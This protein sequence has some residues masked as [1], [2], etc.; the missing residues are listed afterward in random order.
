MTKWSD[1]SFPNI[2]V[3]NTRIP[4]LHTQVGYSGRN[5]FGLL[6]Y[7]LEGTVH[8]HD[9]DERVGVGAVDV[10]WIAIRRPAGDTLAVE[11]RVVA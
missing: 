11:R 9:D 2:L 7:W 5:G 10:D 6:C 4:D 8:Q 3:V 1:P